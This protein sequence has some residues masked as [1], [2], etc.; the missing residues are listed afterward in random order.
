MAFINSAEDFWSFIK[1]R[2]EKFNEPEDS[3]SV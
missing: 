2:L 1:R 3:Y